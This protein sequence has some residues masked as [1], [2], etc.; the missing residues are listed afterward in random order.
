MMLFYL[1][2]FLHLIEIN[3]GITSPIL[4]YTTYNH[5]IELKTNVTD[6][7]WTTN[8]INQEILFELHIHTTG[9]IALGISPSGGMNGADIGVGWIDQS[10]NVHFQDRYALSTITPIVDNTT[11]D[12]FA[13]QGREQNG[14][15]A[16]QFKRS[17]D[18]CDSMDVSIKSGTN[19]LI[20][21]YGLID[22]TNDITYHETRRDSRTLSLRSYN[23]PPLESEFTR[24]AHFDFRLNNYSI[25]SIDTTYFCK[26]Y[27]TPTNYSSKRHVIANQFLIESSNRDF[28]HHILMYECDS[29][30]QFNDSNLPEGLCYNVKSQ[31]QSC[32]I[33]IATGW[34][35]GGDYMTEYPKEA[36]YPI[37]GDFQ[38]KYYMIEIHFNNPNQISNITDSSGIRFYIGNQ[39]RQYDIGYLTFGTDILPTSLAIPPNVQNFIV[40]SYCPINA[41]ISIPMSGITVISAFPHAHLQGRSISTKIIRNQ[42]AVQYLFNGETFDFNYQ[43]E[44]RLA[45]PIKIYSGD[46]FATRCVYNTMNKTRITL[47]GESV[48]DEMCLH[49]FTYY[50]RMNNTSICLNRI[51]FS[52]WQMLMNKNISAIFSFDEFENWLMNINWTSQ[53]V[54]QWQEFYN[55]ASRL[56]LYGGEANLQHLMLSRLQKYEDLKQKECN[57]SSTGNNTTVIIPSFNTIVFLAIY[58][59]ILIKY[60]ML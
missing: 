9:W 49:I 36:G 54:T 3:N 53:L 43:F 4:P 50:P 11:N 26:I 46:E 17:F 40:D 15:T 51:S 42:T 6:L 37:G 41:T 18:T 19:N 47:G 20:Y 35:V 28:I 32:A 34:A 48:H 33:N 57:K 10:G 23:D 7:W 14:W 60:L 31:I 56:V 52:S 29:T 2:V 8:E 30:V 27:K 55:N 38:I 22:P 59:M 39:L 16:I 13:L 12:W 58:L 5:S 44:H 21:A 45:E 1:V 24:F 25:P